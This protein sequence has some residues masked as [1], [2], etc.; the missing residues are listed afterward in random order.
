VQYDFSKAEL[1][2]IGRPNLRLIPL[3]KLDRDT[4]VP[5][6]VCG[7]HTTVNEL[8]ND[9]LRMSS[10]SKAIEGAHAPRRQR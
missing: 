2:K 5:G 6:R 10:L 1:G 9:L 4:E 8:V 7:S 3:R